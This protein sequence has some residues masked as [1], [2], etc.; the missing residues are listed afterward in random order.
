MLDGQERF[1]STGKGKKRRITSIVQHEDQANA[2]YCILSHTRDPTVNP[3]DLINTDCGGAMSSVPERVQLTVNHSKYFVE[4]KSRALSKIPCH[5]NGVEAT[6]FPIQQSFKNKRGFKRIENRT[7]LKQ[8]LDEF[9][10]SQNFTNNSAEDKFFT[11]LMCC[12]DIYASD[13]IQRGT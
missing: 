12:V 9:D 3:A 5:I 8:F 13:I 1:P 6:H 11:A 10:W 2:Q 7:S 4:P